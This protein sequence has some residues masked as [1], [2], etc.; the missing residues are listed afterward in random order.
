MKEDLGAV[1]GSSPAGQAASHLVAS[2]FDPA[3]EA[4]VLWLRQEASFARHAQQASRGRSI[5]TY[6][7]G[8]KDAYLLAADA[9]EN[10]DYEICQ[11]EEQG[12]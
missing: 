3:R 10:G 2:R 12:Q 7:M 6:R 1:T 5:S 9:I 8:Q 11:S 4:I